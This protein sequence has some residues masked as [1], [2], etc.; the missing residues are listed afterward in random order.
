MYWNVHM[1]LYSLWRFITLNLPNE[2]YIYYKEDAKIKIISL[3]KW[4]YVLKLTLPF[5]VIENK[6]PELIVI[7]RFPIYL[8]VQKPPSESLKFAPGKSLRE[9]EDRTQLKHSTL[10]GKLPEVSCD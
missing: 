8:S 4:F 3:F 5:Q 9:Q 1:I 2:F 6:T 10:F 7:H